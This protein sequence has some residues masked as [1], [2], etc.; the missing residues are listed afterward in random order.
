MICAEHSASAQGNSKNPCAKRALI[1]GITGQD[2]SYLAELLLEKGYEVHGLIRRGSTFNTGR[3]EHLYKDPHISDSQLL[4]HYSDLTDSSSISRLLEKINPSEIYH[5]GAQSHV[6]VSFDM[7]EF[8]ADVTGIGTLRILDAIRESSIRTKFYQASSSEMFGNVAEV[9]QKE[10]TPF[11]PRSPYACAKVF[12]FSITRNYR[13]SYG[14][15]ACNGILFNHESPRRGETFV[16]RKISRGLSRI[17]LGLDDCLYLGNLD[18]M[19]DWGYAKDYVEAMWRML[20]QPKPDD[21]VVATNESH[22]IREFVDEACKCLDFD[23]QWKG[24]G[25]DE[26]GID[27]KSDKVLI[28]VDPH[29]FRPS[30][31]DYLR[32]DYTK[33]RE[34]LGWQPSVRFVDLVRIM[35]DAD[36]AMEEGKVDSK[37]W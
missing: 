5:L 27:T 16:T 21:Y 12:A 20:Q 25:E 15:F 23:L 7:P 10:T 31:V 13:E 33:A 17:R 19:R 18:A 28:R 36:L 37:R 34:Q 24:T 35:V 26:V 2:G 30:E 11:Y 4:L 6:K 9:P 1:T 14:L 3:I 29:Y 32:G 8:T 22:S